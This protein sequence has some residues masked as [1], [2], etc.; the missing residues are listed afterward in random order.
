MPIN[1][2]QINNKPGYKWGTQG[3]CYH[4]DPQNKSSETRAWNKAREQGIAI[5]DY[6]RETLN[7]LM[8]IR[9]KLK[10]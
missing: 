5:G 4:Y 3:K 1:Q 6:F 7:K 10:K 9:K 8:E 2:C